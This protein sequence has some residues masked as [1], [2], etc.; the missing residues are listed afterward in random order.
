[1][2]IKP[3]IDL[4]QLIAVSMSALPNSKEEVENIKHDILLDAER[5]RDAYAP[6]IQINY[7]TL[8][9]KNLFNYIKRNV[10]AS[11]SVDFLP[12]G[13]HTEDIIGDFRIETPTIMSWQNGNSGKNFVIS[14]DNASER[15][16]RK[17]LNNIVT[18]IL[19]S[20]P[21]KCFRLHFIDLTYSGQASFLTQHLDKSIYDDLITEYDKCR[22]L[23]D[24][25]K[26]KMNDSLEDYGGN[27]VDYNQNK[28]NTRDQ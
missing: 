19:I 23:Q 1:M 8:D 16:A 3:I 25:L 27:L 17:V 4:S 12:D 14:Y 11:T 7:N 10:S 15:K 28:G 6:L 26:E 13:F 2:T 20:L 5:I 24:E 18:N 22:V 9:A 21:S